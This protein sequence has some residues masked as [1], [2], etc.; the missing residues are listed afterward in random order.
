[1]DE[2]GVEGACR[3]ER[4]RRLLSRHPPMGVEVEKAKTGR[5]EEHIDVYTKPGSGKLQASRF[6]HGMEFFWLIKEGANAPEG[7]M[8][9]LK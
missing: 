2:L 4:E 5:D 9:M 6:H 8:R 1:M 7:W 3:G